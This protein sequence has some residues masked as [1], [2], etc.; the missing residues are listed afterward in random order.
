MPSST[1]T[2]VV[3]TFLRALRTGD[4][5]L[6]AS[7]A[8][9]HAELGVLLAPPGPKTAAV[10]TPLPELT[11]IDL[12]GERQLITLQQEQR[13]LLLVVRATQFGPRLDLRHLI[14]AAHP[15]NPCRATARAFY[16]AL[17]CGD[18]ATLRALAF[19]TT[20]IEA[21]GA[22]DGLPS[23]LDIE[24]TVQALGLV[25]L[26]LGEAFTVPNGVQF[27]SARHLELGIV[28]LAGLTPTG[29]IPF[30]L[31][32]RDDQWKVI[33]LHFLQ[34]AAQEQPNRTPAARVVSSPR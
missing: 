16:R 22:A 30:L 7:V 15:D 25:E 23:L 29:E 5:D 9:P 14:A 18:L 27:V 32:P 10:E 11:S 2:A 20:G 24:P 12:P 17:L 34:A 26:G 28:V 21:L 8:L 31:R 33:A 1:T 4:R 6:L 3:R 19:D 13:Q